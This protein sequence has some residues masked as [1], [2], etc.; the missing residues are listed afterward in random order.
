[1]SYPKAIYLSGPIA[2]LSYEDARNGWR[3]KFEALMTGSPIVCLSPMRGKDGLRGVS[4]LGKPT[5]GVSFGEDV[6]MSNKGILTRDFNDVKMCDA[7]IVNV[8]GAKVVSIGTCVEVG[9]ADAMR[10][11]IVVVI[12]KEGN[13]HD[14]I[15]ITQTAGYRMESLEDAARVL[16]FLLTPGV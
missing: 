1:M 3:P 16:R 6:I 15:F 2:G 11:P 14:H 8:L 10:K 4:L 12:E 7:M 9:W 13:P 5:D